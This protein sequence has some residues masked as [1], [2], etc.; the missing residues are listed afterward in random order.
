MKYIKLFQTIAD[1]Q[2]AELDYPNTNYV[3]ENSKANIEKEAPLDQEHIVAKYNITDTSNPTK[4]LNDAFNITYMIVD[5]VQQQSVTTGYTFS[6]T[7]EHKVKYK[8]NSYW[9]GRLTFREC[10]HLVSITIP[11]S[12]TS[13]AREAFYQCSG[14]TSVTIG[15]GVTSIGSSAFSVSGLININIPSGVTSIDGRAFQECGSLTSV[16]I[17]DS[18]TSI[19]FQAFALC[20]NLTNVTVN[21]TTPPTLGGNAFNETNNCPI[22]VPAAS[23]NAYKAAANWSTYASRIR[24]IQ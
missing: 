11:D 22:Y 19:G 10:S 5:G 16:T 4:I 7:G 8:V 24:A 12:V 14:L 17:P 18:V 2:A 9:D 1:K 23:V 13:I 21:A 6:T 20:N 3:V 15:N